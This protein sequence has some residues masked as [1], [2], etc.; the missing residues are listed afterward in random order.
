MMVGQNL[1]NQQLQQLVDKSIMEGDLDGDGKLNFNE[2]Q[3]MVKNNDLIAKGLTLA[4]G[5]V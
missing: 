4:A 5:R 3:S 2:F 1:S